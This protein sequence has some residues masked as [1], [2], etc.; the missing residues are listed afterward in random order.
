MRLCDR[1]TNEVPCMDE[2]K[3]LV[4]IEK[5]IKVLEENNVNYW[6]DYGSLLGIIRDH[7][8]IPWDTDIETYAYYSNELQKYQLAK[9]FEY[10]NMQVEMYPVHLEILENDKNVS[11]SVSW[12]NEFFFTKPLS[13]FCFIYQLLLGWELLRRYKSYIVR[14]K[15]NL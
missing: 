7:K 2:K 13:L 9:S 10:K 6:F 8:F 12:V 3:A 15:V 1:T 11:M 5:L 14:V 4:S